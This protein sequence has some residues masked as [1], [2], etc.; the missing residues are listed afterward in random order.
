MDGGTV[1][2]TWGT[3]A[4]TSA[5]DSRKVSLKIQFHLKGQ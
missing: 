2:Q 3:K 4:K 1:V 5:V